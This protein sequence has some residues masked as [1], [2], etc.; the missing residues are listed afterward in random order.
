[1]IWGVNSRQLNRPTKE[2][3]ADKDKD[4]TEDKEKVKK[5]KKKKE[6]PP[7][8]VNQHGI[9]S[10][11]QKKPEGTD[12]RQVTPEA[13]KVPEGVNFLSPLPPKPEPP[14][15][16]VFKPQKKVVVKVIDPPSFHPVR[17]TTTDPT[18]FFHHLKVR[19]FLLQC[20]SL[21]V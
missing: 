12:R 5:P 4:S 16:Q 7:P 2:P 1:V 17:T 8:A 19:E 10:F 18:T 14:R 6:K 21:S 3:S 9:A 13:A 20:T 11:F 15:P